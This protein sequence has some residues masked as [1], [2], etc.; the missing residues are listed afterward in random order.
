MIS[1]DYT[2]SATEYHT[3]SIT[4]Q[5]QIQTLTLTSFI[6]RHDIRDEGN[7]KVIKIAFNMT[8]WVVYF[9]PWTTANGLR[10]NHHPTIPLHGIVYIVCQAHLILEGHLESTKKLASVP[11]KICFKQLC[12]TWEE[13]WM[14]V[15][16][17]HRITELTAQSRNM[18]GGLLY[19]SMATFS[20]L[21]DYI[22]LQSLLTQWPLIK[23]EIKNAPNLGKNRKFSFRFY[24]L[25]TGQ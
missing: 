24:Q 5:I 10:P 16:L 25:Q 6:C 19:H 23:K 17:N 15:K 8:W 9:A 18:S 12:S 3:I 4:C 13:H 21:W 7:A 2:V 22:W 1:H 11:L 14:Q 20:T